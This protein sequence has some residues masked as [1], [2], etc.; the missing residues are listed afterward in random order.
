MRRIKVFLVLSPRMTEGA[1]RQSNRRLSFWRLRLNS[2]RE[3]M[4][5]MIRR[6][7]LAKGSIS[8]S[9]TYKH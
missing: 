9:R 4:L 5:A 2:A 6:R 7:P 3:Y 8:N 1:E